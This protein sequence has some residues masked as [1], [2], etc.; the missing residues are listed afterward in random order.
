MRPSRANMRV[1]GIYGLVYSYLRQR[2]S[3]EL[4]LVTETSFDA[5]GTPLM[6]HNA[7]CYPYVMVAGIR[8]GASTTSQGRGTRYAYV[9]GRQAVD[10]LHIMK[11]KVRTLEGHEKYADIAVIRRFLPTPLALQMP[12]SMR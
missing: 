7:E 6:A 9:K 5:G 10:I 12:W 11:I 3:D 8:Y 1:M 4:R 2:W